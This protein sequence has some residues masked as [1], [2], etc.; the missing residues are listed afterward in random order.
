MK[1][2]DAAKTPKGH[3][4]KV[5]S[6]RTGLTP[7]VL[8][9]WE[10]RYGV[11]RPMRTA[12]GR[13]L[14]SDSDIERLRLLRQATLSG[15]RVGDVA[16]LPTS[17]LTD[18]VREDER[19]LQ[20]VPTTNGGGPSP[21]QRA[22]TLE[23]A[24]AAVHDLDAPRL[25]EILT[26]SLMVHGAGEFIERVAAPLLHRIGLDWEE[27]RLGPYIEHAAITVIRQVVGRTL[28]W[29]TKQDDAPV[30]VAGTPAGQR[31]EIGALLAASAALSE[32]WSV[33]YLGP[34]L[35]A[36]EI[37][38]A[39]EQAGAA[40]VALSVVHPADDSALGRELRRLRELLPARV[41]IVVGGAAAPSYERALKRID[42]EIVPDIATFRTVL[43]R[44]G[45]RAST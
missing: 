2:N 34:D 7:E 32:G 43:A 18:L 5:V 15:R 8:R 31:H 37:A 44:F 35:P 22:E 10:K 29:R 20:R 26:R 4:I 13:R 21:K 17:A 33:V 19:E 1:A 25:E 24:M 27:G 11:V 36:A 39:A 9:V 42:A 6:R 45:G 41:G 40:V 38:R 12:T 14:Y 30:L 3:P 28:I 23:E 16:Q